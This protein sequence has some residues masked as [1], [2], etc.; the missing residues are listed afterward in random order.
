MKR[1]NGEKGS[2]S[3]VHFITLPK[4]VVNNSLHTVADLMRSKGGPR[5]LNLFSAFPLRQIRA[6]RGQK[7]KSQVRAP[8]SSVVVC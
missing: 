7:K 4:S 3:C 2:Y 1:N 6:H 5:A 8:N